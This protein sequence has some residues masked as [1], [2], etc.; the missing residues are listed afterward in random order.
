VSA[1]VAVLPFIP[2]ARLQR[3]GLRA[4]LER[5]ERAIDRPYTRA[6]SQHLDRCLM[7]FERVA[8]RP[9]RHAA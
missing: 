5:A 2:V 9:L 7:A 3:V 6:A 4:R 8:Q 1:L